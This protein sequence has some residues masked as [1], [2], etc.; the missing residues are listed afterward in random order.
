MDHIVKRKGHKEPF[1]ARKIYASVFAACL[2][3]R[4]K[5]EEAELIAHMVSDEVEKGLKKEKQMESHKI[6]KLVTESLKKYNSDAAY[7]YDTHRD[8]S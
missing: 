8:I 5:D 4:M 6:H 7:I 1:D 2:V 3:L